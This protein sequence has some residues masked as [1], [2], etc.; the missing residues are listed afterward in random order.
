LA[1]E[2]AEAASLQEVDASAGAFKLP[3]DQTTQ[4]QD[5]SVFIITFKS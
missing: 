4:T 2:E 5:S 1:D 3:T